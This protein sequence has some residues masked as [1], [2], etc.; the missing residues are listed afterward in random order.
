[1]GGVADDRLMVVALPY[2]QGWEAPIAPDSSSDLCLD[3]A[4][5]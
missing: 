3:M 4:Y 5:N 1:M 2:L